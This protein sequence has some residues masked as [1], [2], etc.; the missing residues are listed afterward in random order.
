MARLVFRLL[1][2]G[3]LVERVVT[4]ERGEA[5]EEAGRGGAP[6]PGQERVLAP[7]VRVRERVIGA[8]HRARAECD[9][10][11]LFFFFT[12]SNLEVGSHH[13]SVFHPS[14]RAPRSL[15]APHTAPRIATS[16]ARTH[17]NA[18]D[19]ELKRNI[20]ILGAWLAA[21]RVAP[22]VCDLVQGALAK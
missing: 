14:R 20:V 9:R 5:E 17:P 1:L 2:R 7:R 11:V 3:G 10:S 15:G 6:R 19:A 22:Y 12:S 13:S 21:I 18:M 4:P 8:G 16:H